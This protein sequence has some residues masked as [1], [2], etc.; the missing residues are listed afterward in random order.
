LI[1]RLGD[2]IDDRHVKWIDRNTE[3]R[4]ESMAEFYRLCKTLQEIKQQIGNSMFES[5]EA[6]KQSILIV[7]SILENAAYT[8][9]NS[10]ILTNINYAYAY[11]YYVVTLATKILFS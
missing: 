11:H 7:S 1:C 3:L 10:T 8:E 5:L 9:V 2:I 6:G 4:H